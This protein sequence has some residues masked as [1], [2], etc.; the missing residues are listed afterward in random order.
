MA[1]TA[2]ADVAI[3]IAITLITVTLTVYKLNKLIAGILYLGI[4]GATFML[5]TTDFA[6]TGNLIGM[7]IMA[8][9]LL[10]MI[11]QFIP[12]SKTLSS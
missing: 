8:I 3:L 7:I 12:E 2:Q 5:D 6:N 11:Y 4:G 9:G 10:V 1:L